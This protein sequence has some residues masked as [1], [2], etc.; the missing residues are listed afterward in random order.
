MA[1]LLLE[2][3]A[4]VDLDFG[5]FFFDFLAV[6]V[7]VVVVVVVSGVVLSS[8][9]LSFRFLLFFSPPLATTAV[10][11]GVAGKNDLDSSAPTGVAWTGEACAASVGVAD[12]VNAGGFNELAD[13]ECAG[14]AMAAMVGVASEV[15]RGEGTGRAAMAARTG[16]AGMARAGEE[17]T[18]RTASAG[19]A[20]I[21]E[22]GLGEG[23]VMTVLWVFVGGCRLTLLTVPSQ[24]RSPRSS[25]SRSV[26]GQCAQRG[27]SVVAEHRSEDKASYTLHAWRSLLSEGSERKFGSFE[28]AEFDLVAFMQVLESSSADTFRV[29]C[30]CRP[31]DIFLCSP[32]FSSTLYP[33]RLVLL[34]NVAFDRPHSPSGDPFD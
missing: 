6:L 19:L 13:N 16:D 26:C 1:G 12:R 15:W 7:L 17:G 3:A 22:T 11:V 31:F 8:A 10:C 24:S 27:E 25:S 20:T 14:D 28:L 9:A 23:G 29:V 18:A 32:S 5:L 4:A 21:A 2:E 34:F 30:S 33:R